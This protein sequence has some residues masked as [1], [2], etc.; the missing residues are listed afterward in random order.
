MDLR[1]DSTR[2]L[3]LICIGMA[4]VMWAVGFGFDRVLARDGYYASLYQKQQLEEELTVA[5]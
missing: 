3:V 2:R 1:K 4:L 5:S